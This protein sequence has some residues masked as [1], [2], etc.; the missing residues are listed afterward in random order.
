MT[1]TSN[2]SRI[3]KDSVRDGSS[4]IESESEDESKRVLFSETINAR[5]R[6]GHRHAIDEPASPRNESSDSSYLCRLHP[7][8]DNA[9]EVSLWSVDQVGAFVRSL[10]G[11]HSLV[12]TFRK[13]GI[14][15]QSLLLLT[16]DHLLDHLSVCLGHAI[17]LL[18]AINKRSQFCQQ[19]NHC[20]SCH[21]H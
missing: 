9:Q 16:E 19:C 14:D 20:L 10:F 7:C 4:S 5:N 8:N 2:D 1:K 15:G 11:D 17:K 3:D 6:P 18:S 12:E 21:S 13:E